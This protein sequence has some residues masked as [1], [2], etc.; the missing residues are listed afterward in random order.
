MAHRAQRLLSLLVP[1]LSYGAIENDLGVEPLKVYNRGSDAVTSSES[2]LIP[3]QNFDLDTIIE[4]SDT[5]SHFYLSSNRADA[6]QRESMLATLIMHW[7]EEAHGQRHRLPDHEWTSE[8]ALYLDK[9][10]DLRVSHVNEW[11]SVNLTRFKADHAEVEAL[12]RALDTFAIELRSGQINKYAPSCYSLNIAAG[13]M[14]SF[15]KQSVV[16][17]IFPA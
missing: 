15:V 8:L 17:A 14:S 2:I 10:A 1:A 13:R 5:L 6:S 7:S 12:R 4:T 11:I 9:L 16:H 3:P